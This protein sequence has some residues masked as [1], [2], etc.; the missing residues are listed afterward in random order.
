[1]FGENGHAVKRV[2]EYLIRPETC[3]EVIFGLRQV[4]HLRAD[5]AR[6]SHVTG[7]L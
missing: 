7:N 5:N 2:G 6:A 1:M 3:S 4:H